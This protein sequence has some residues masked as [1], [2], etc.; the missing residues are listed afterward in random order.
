[1]IKRTPL[2]RNQTPLSKGNGLQR[3]PYKLRAKSAL[4][5]VR[6]LKDNKDRA[7]QTI[8][9]MK[10]WDPLRP[11]QRVCYETGVRLYP[12]DNSY[13]LNSYFHHVLPKERFPQFR[14]SP[15]N[16][17]LVSVSTHNQ[18]ETYPQACPKIYALYLH[19]MSKLSTL[20]P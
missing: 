9:F 10:I 11:E 4:A 17:I 6:E 2:K 20:Q 7:E 12:D 3:K 8:C 13:P 15:W 16:I 18:Y 1:M 5:I 14:F 19:Y